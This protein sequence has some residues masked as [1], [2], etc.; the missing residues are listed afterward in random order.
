MADPSVKPR[1]FHLTPDRLVIGLLVMECLLWLSERFRWFGF[2]EKKGWTVLIAVAVV[3]AAFLL[4]LLWFVVAL[5]FRSRFQFSIRSLLMLVVVVA[6]PCSWMAVE[7]KKAREQSEVLEPIRQSALTVEYDWQVDVD[8]RGLLNVQPPASQWLRNLLGDD[9]FAGLALVGFNGLQI[10]DAELEHFSLTS[11]PELQF[12]GL[13]FTDITDAGLADIKGLTR[14]KGL[15]LTGNHITDAGLRHIKDLTEL[16]SLTLGGTKVTDTGLEHL[17]GLTNLQSLE[18]SASKVTGRG[19]TNLE[20][21]T[22]LDSL[23]LSASDVSDAGL[24]HLKRLPKLQ[25]LDLSFTH[26]TD[27][28]LDR[29]EGLNQ[30]R[31]LNLSG[32][33]VTTEGVRKLQQALPKCK[34][35]H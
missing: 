26:L 19:L 20:G 23:D 11:I 9:F 1:W 25:S 5:V 2:N 30:L 32:T 21:L 12:V 27:V 18:L 29:L 15:W 14:L 22:K 24:D 10:T 33:E 31:L 3:G 7:M 35:I 28:G 8:G 6:V 16:R 17:R 13:P 34:I 4:M